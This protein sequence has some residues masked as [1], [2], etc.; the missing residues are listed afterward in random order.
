MFVCPLSA[1]AWPQEVEFRTQ[2]TAGERKGQISRDLWRIGGFS[3]FCPDGAAQCPASEQ[4]LEIRF[5][6]ACDA[7]ATDLLIT[8][9]KA[10][11]RKGGVEQGVVLDSGLPLAAKD[12]RRLE[13]VGA[14]LHASREWSVPEEE[15]EDLLS[16]A[17]MLRRGSGFLS[18]SGSFILSSGNSNSAGGG[19]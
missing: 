4:E 1:L 8:D 15:A 5:L 14:M 3:R 18:T 9:Q 2:W 6:G 13:A 10:I 19:R 11:V 16:L 17:R 12:R 7:R